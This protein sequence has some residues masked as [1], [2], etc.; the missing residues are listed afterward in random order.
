MLKQWL[1]KQNS[2]KQAYTEYMPGFT[3]S[4]SVDLTIV[5]AGK[6]GHIEPNNGRLR[7]MRS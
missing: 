7:S 5:D 4:N 6:L 1:R 2:N 3:C